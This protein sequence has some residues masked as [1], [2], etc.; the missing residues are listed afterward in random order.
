MDTHTSH[1]RKPF[2]SVHLVIV[3]RQMSRFPATESDDY[4]KEYE[5]RDCA[6]APDRAMD[7]SVRATAKLGSMRSPAP[8][9]Y[10]T[11]GSS[12]MFGGLAPPPD[13]LQG[14]LLAN[15]RNE[16]LLR[17]RALGALSAG[18]QA[19]EVAEI[20]RRRLAMEWNARNSL[21]TLPPLSPNTAPNTLSYSDPLS[22]SF[23]G[24]LSH[25][26]VSSKLIS[27]IQSSR[28]RP[29]GMEPPLKKARSALPTAAAVELLPPSAMKRIA[30]G[31]PL[32]TTFGPANTPRV[33]DLDSFRQSW[34]RLERLSDA[35]DDTDA[36]QAAFV[37][38]FFTR[39]LYCHS[40]DHILARIQDLR[41]EARGKGSRDCN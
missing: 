23:S 41:S 15:V 6:R 16:D 39:T 24:R 3:C 22:H 27:Y 19:T 4:G 2:F 30:G 13:H 10:Q 32:P 7:I 1:F 40:N 14:C 35:M 38:E 18:S 37:K 17:L 8:L 26:A 31:Y 34:E 12:S 9:D 36:D 5:D 28:E 21:L 25:S 29:S 33:R 20:V 11:H